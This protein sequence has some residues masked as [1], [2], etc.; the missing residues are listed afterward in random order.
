MGA[1]RFT[2]TGWEAIEDLLACASP[3]EGEVC[4]RW[5]VKH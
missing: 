3:F 5:P 2:L 1:A 4:Q